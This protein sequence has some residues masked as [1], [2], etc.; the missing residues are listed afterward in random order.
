M[1]GMVNSWS[2]HDYT[3]LNNAVY[4]ILQPEFQEYQI[5]KYTHFFGAW[6]KALM[7]TDLTPSGDPT[8]LIQKLKLC[9]YPGH[10]KWTVTA[11][12]EYR[13]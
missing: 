9:P 10:W 13:S 11:I 12:R 1:G 5:I 6:Q 2:C 3:S 8:T 7:T 4:G